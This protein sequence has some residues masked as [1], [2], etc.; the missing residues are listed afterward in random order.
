MSSIEQINVLH[1]IGATVA[2][3]AEVMASSVARALTKYGVRIGIFALSGTVDEVGHRVRAE[4]LEDGLFFRCGP[5]GEVGIRALLEYAHALRCFNPNIVHLHTP[6]TELAHALVGWSVSAQI[7][8][9]IHTTALARGRLHRW[10]CNHNRAFVSV[11]CS[12]AVAAAHVIWASPTVVIPNGVDF[13]W[14]PQTFRSRFEACSKLGLSPDMRHFVMV[15]GMAGETPARSPKAHDVAITAWNKAALDSNRHALHFIGDGPLRSVLERS[16]KDVPGI[17]F[18]GI[19][20]CV[21]DWLCA[22]DVFVMPS[23]HEGLPLAGIEALG[24]GL[25]CIFSEIPPLLELQPSNALWCRKGDPE[26]LA[27]CFQMAARSGD[28]RREVRFEEFRVKYGIANMARSYL[29]YYKT[30]LAQSA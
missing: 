29:N 20:A 27:T 7:A 11:A 9:T 19:S 2:G 22:A 26:S 10:A 24:T 15:G 12:E 18:H 14:P 5:E 3:G 21:G 16:A 1:A 6:N 23:R 17:V 13:S 8:R 30:L 28:E 4:L 25:A